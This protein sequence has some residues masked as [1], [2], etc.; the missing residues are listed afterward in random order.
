MQCPVCTQKPET[1]QLADAMRSQS[2]S[3]QQHGTFHDLL[4]HSPEPF[5]L[6]AKFFQL[7]LFNQLVDENEPVDVSVIA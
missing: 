2:E 5:E 1:Q 3:R 7:G 6:L 4:D